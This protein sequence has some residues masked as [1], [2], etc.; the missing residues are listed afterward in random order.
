MS[1]ST[2]SLLEVILG[3]VVLALL[4]GLAL[5]VGDLGQRNRGAVATNAPG[6][7]PVHFT[8]REWNRI[9]E[10]E[11]TAFGIENTAKQI[12]MIVVAT[13][14]RQG[15]CRDFI[16]DA[17]TIENREELIAKILRSP[18]EAGLMSRMSMLYLLYDPD[19][20]EPPEVLSVVVSNVSNAALSYSP[21]NFYFR[22]RQRIIP[23]RDYFLV[24][25]EK[26]RS[27]GV[28]EPK[29]SIHGCI[30]LA[31]PNWGLN[32]NN[33]FEFWYGHNFGI[34]SNF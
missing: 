30:I 22:Q 26:F 25:Q 16:I 7:A 33:A 2:P 28:L 4:V 34:I 3:V 12:V 21:S 29:E 24:G 32:C 31:S 13:R 27:G 20:D 15:A 6:Y 10:G 17:G 23:I 8:S 1:E 5:G 18:S 19:V 11:R 9:P 14:D